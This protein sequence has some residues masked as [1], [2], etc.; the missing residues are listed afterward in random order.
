MDDD[1]PAAY[2]PAP[3][4]K[5]KSGKLKKTKPSKHTVKFKKMFGDDV[6]ENPLALA[7]LAYGAA[8]LATKI[9]PSTYAGAAT[10]IGQGVSKAKD[11][12]SSKMSKK[13]KTNE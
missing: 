11:Y 7:P 6:N 9:Q 3:G 2:T 12:V 5:D 4:D 8:R 10:M 1:N 13:K